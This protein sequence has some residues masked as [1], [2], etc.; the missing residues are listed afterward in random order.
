MGMLFKDLKKKKVFVCFSKDLLRSNL[1][2]ILHIQLSVHVRKDD[3][4]WSL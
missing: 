4:T 3:D 2:F 1:S